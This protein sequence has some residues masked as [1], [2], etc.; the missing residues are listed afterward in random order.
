MASNSDELVQKY[1]DLT[2][3]DS[4]KTLVENISVMDNKLNDAINRI[5]ELETKNDS[6]E[7]RILL[8]EG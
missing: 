5:E 7:A 3:K 8:L 6:L 1:E 4:L 2:F